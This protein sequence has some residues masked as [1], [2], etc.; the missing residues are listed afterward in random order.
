MRKKTK[1]SAAT[2]DNDATGLPPLDD[3]LFGC[4]KTMS[5]KPSDAWKAAEQVAQNT[6]LTESADGEVTSEDG[7][8]EDHTRS[9]FVH[10]N[11]WGVADG[12]P[13]IND[14]TRGELH[15]RLDQ[16]HRIVTRLK[17]ALLDGTLPDGDGGLTAQYLHER[18]RVYYRLHQLALD[19]H[20]TAEHYAQGFE[21]GYADCMLSV[22]VTKDGRWAVAIDHANG[23][24]EVVTDP[25]RLCE[26]ESFME[27]YRYGK[28]CRVNGDDH[29]AAELVCG[30]RKTA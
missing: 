30:T 10:V 29:V 12:E 27:G 14:R 16:N 1:G 19:D 7:T 17:A 13:E 18:R 28:L 2:A 4:W 23:G 3:D 15:R 8:P 21:T 5:N 11:V 20:D 22:T 6:L 25:R 26:M 9:K 24:Y